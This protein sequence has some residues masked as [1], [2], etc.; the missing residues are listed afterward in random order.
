MG[1]VRC[2][3]VRHGASPIALICIANVFRCS[4]VRTEWLAAAAAAAVGLRAGF[5][6]RRL[7]P[8]S[9]RRSLIW[10]P[11][12][13]VLRAGRRTCHDMEVRP[14]CRLITPNYLPVNRGFILKKHRRSAW[15]KE[16]W[17]EREFRLPIA[18]RAIHGRLEEIKS[19]IK[20]QVSRWN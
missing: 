14:T 18:R 8:T 6:H 4:F 17:R 15:W 7:L 20:S 11:V 12:M 16:R 1:A 13:Y 5:D 2:G 10:R 3:H 19:L 9:A